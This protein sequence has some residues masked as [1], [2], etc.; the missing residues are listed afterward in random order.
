VN[1]PISIHYSIEKYIL[2]SQGLVIKGLFTVNQ[3]AECS[4]ESVQNC[5]IC[6]KV[7]IK[8]LN[9]QEIDNT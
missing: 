6:G 5:E 9:I 4:P 7:K 2:Q 8:A 1:N 3:T